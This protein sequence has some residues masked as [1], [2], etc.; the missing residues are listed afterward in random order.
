MRANDSLRILHKTN[1]LRLI[2]AGG[3]KEKGRNSIKQSHKK[4]ENQI[5][6]I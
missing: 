6:N 3:L 1:A 2:A 5:Y 4:K